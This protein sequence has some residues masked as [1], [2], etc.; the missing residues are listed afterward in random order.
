MFFKDS[1]AKIV[2]NNKGLDFIKNQDFNKTEFK[3]LEKAY[4]LAKQNYDKHYFNL[5]LNSTKTIYKIKPDLNLLITL[6][7]KRIDFKF[8]KTEFPK[9]IVFLLEKLNDLEKIRYQRNLKNKKKNLEK[10]ENFKNLFLILATDLRVI[11]IRLVQ[12]L[13]EAKNFHN[14]PEKEAKKMGEEILDIYSPIAGRLGICKL[15]GEL[16]DCSFPFVYPKEYKNLMEQLKESYK[17]R[18]SY[19]NKNKKILEEKLK[20]EDIHL[21]GVQ[22]RSKYCYSLFQKI[23]KH[24]G[25]ISKIYDL[26]AIRIIVETI[27][28]CY[29]VLGVIHKHWK[30]LPNRIK[31]YIALPKPNGYRSLHTTVFFVQGKIVEIQIRTKKMHQH[32][33]YGIACHWHYNENKGFKSYLK[34]IIVKVSKKR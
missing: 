25:D 30:P 9:Q 5:V 32:A 2:S 20:K 8:V 13:E 6:F 15:K 4:F 31:D 23:K 17:E 21:I 33:E 28:D 26:V 24:Q 19:L 14:Y 34:K 12:K 27:E 29:K 18:E 16:E 10:I 3:F 11:L 7:L 1:L 22:T